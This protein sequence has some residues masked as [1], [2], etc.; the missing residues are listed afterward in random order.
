MGNRLKIFLEYKNRMY[1]HVVL[2]LP[3]EKKMTLRIDNFNTEEWVDYFQV[4]DRYCTVAATC[5]NTHHGEYSGS[6]G[7]IE[8]SWLA[9]QATFRWST[10]EFNIKP[11]MIA[12][13]D[14]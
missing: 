3:E 9:K 6:E 5:K 2:S 12:Y 14:F 7:F 1:C 11:N 8:D 4:Y 13:I 10:D